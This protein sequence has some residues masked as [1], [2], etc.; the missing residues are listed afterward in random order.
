MQSARFTA[1]MMIAGLLAL[2]YVVC[3]MTKKPPS[4]A[5]EAVEQA[6]TNFK[7][8]RNTGK[9]YIMPPLATP[10]C[11]NYSANVYAGKVPRF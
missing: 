1:L 9:V 2:Y 5:G 11:P 6:G 10:I 8:E 7:G 3:S 4:N